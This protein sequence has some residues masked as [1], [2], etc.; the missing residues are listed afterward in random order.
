MV[1]RKEIMDFVSPVWAKYIREVTL[2]GNPIANGGRIRKCF[3]YLN[4]H[5]EVYTVL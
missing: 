3:N 5:P 4:D 2:S 1:G